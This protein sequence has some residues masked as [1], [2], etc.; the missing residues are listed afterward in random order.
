M[1]ACDCVQEAKRGYTC[2]QYA[3]AICVS[4]FSAIEH[5]SFLLALA[6]LSLV[7][8]FCVVQ[9]GIEYK[10]SDSKISS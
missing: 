7:R 10:D 6:D 8:I 9:K 4:R 2:R 3:N 1:A 5:V